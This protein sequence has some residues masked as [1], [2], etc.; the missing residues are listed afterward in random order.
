MLSGHFDTI[1]IL[2]LQI[3]NHVSFIRSVPSVPFYLIPKHRRISVL[4]VS[5]E[6][7]FLFSFCFCLFWFDF[8]ETGSHC[9]A[10]VGME[11]TL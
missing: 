2:T 5:S 7:G 8:F 11:L 4:Q 3:S 10:P 6:E 9:E 1:A